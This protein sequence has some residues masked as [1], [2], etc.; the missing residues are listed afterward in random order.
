[1]MIVTLLVI[2]GS[3]LVIILFPSTLANNTLLFILA[4]KLN[5]NVLLILL[6]KSFKLNTSFVIF[7][8]YLLTHPLYGAIICQLSISLTIQYSMLIL[9][10]LKLIIILFISIFSIDNS[11]FSSSP[12]LINLLTF[13]LKVYLQY[14]FTY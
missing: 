9:S 8:Y 2:Y 5:T 6:L 11:T 10:I 14:A 3:S 13:S 4:L 12:P 1:M 7:V